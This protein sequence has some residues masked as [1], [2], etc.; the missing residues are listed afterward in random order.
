MANIGLYVNYKVYE[1]EDKIPENEKFMVGGISYTSS[2]VATPG[3]DVIYG[4]V[5]RHNRASANLRNVTVEGNI[6][7]RLLGSQKAIVGA[8]VGV[9]YGASVVANIV[10]ASIEVRSFVAEVGGVIGAVTSNDKSL[11]YMNTQIVEGE[12]KVTASTMSVGV[13]V[14]AIKVKSDRQIPVIIPQIDVYLNNVQVLDPPVY[15]KM[16]LPS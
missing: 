6:L 1:S 3:K 7:I 13:M 15:G 11:T 12:L 8:L 2:K 4:A 14:G 10:E 9:D 5:A 16:P